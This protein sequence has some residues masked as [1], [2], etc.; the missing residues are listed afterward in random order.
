[1]FVDIEEYVTYLSM[2]EILLISV[3]LSLLAIV[4]VWLIFKFVKNKI[5]T[6]I[7][8][9]RAEKKAWLKNYTRLDR[10]VPQED[11]TEVI[12]DDGDSENISSF[13]W[14]KDNKFYKE[15]E[16]VKAADLQ[17]KMKPRKLQTLLGLIIDLL[18]RGTEESKLA[19]VIMY[20]NQ[21]LNTEDDVIYTIAAIKM[22]VKMCKNGAFRQVNSNNLLPNENVALFNLAKGDCSLALLLLE[23]YIDDAL[24]TVRH[25]KESI[26]KRKKILEIANLSLC[27]GTFA[28]LED[29]NL[30]SGAFELAIELNPH[31]SIAWSRLGDAYKMMGK[32]DKAVWAYANVLNFDNED[33]Y[34][35]QV[36]NASRALYSYYKEH[37]K[38]E[39]A[40]KLLNESYEYYDEIGI[41]N[42]LSDRENKIIDIVEAGEEDSLE[43]VVDA[44]LYKN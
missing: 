42:P 11:D 38:K 37:G 30:A 2:E 7:Q 10:T 18:S 29:Y 20:K 35:Q 44:V 33:V 39:Q 36:A 6:A 5:Y 1:M 23:T 19:Q 8:V 40:A 24:E 43:N 13:D 16:S 9:R 34:N 41:N 17:Y 32:N 14:S 22:F 12:S 4:L 31:S 27:F 25:L 3:F 28:M 15:T 21:H 26:E